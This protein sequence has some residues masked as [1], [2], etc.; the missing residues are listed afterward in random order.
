MCLAKRYKVLQVASWG[1]QV[2]LSLMQYRG[3]CLHRVLVSFPPFTHFTF[4]LDNACRSSWENNQRKY[5]FSDCIAENKLLGMLAGYGLP[6]ISQVC[7][8]CISEGKRWL[9]LSALPWSSPLHCIL[10]P[11]DLSSVESWLTCVLFVCGLLFVWL[12]GFCALFW[13]RVLL[14]VLELNCRTAL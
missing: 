10:I 13:D 7:H 4:S 6:V 5:Q 8:N 9:N 11:S 12:V 14:T 3:C 2:G 1:S